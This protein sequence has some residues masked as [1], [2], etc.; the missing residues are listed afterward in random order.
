MYDSLYANS[1]QNDIHPYNKNVSLKA[2]FAKARRLARSG[3][4]NGGSR[5]SSDAAL[6]FTTESCS[7]K[8]AQAEPGTIA[9]A[10]GSQQKNSSR[11]LGRSMLTD[12][13]FWS[14]AIYSVVNWMVAFADVEG[15]QN[16]CL[17]CLPYLLKDE[18]M[19][20]FPDSI[21]LH[22]VAFHTLVLLARPLGSLGYAF[23]H[24]HGMRQATVRMGL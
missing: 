2:Y 4:H 20:L 22:T 19:V 3:R 13:F 1:R 16:M 11:R 14:C 17:K 18:A 21:K 6:S 12:R 24:S 8:A 9:L 23:P 7:E 15:I 5:S 10:N